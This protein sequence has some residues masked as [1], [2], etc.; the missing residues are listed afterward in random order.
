MKCEDQFVFEACDTFTVTEED[1][2]ACCFVPFF[3]FVKLI[4]L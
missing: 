1:G 3:L 2:K 4:S